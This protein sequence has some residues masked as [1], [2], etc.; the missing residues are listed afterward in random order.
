[1]A[2][3]L[4]LKYIRRDEELFGGC[5]TGSLILGRLQKHLQVEAFQL[6]RLKINPVE[7]VCTPQAERGAIWQTEMVC[8][9]VVQLQAPELVG[10]EVLQLG[11]S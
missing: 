4:L 3:K 8:A 6:W 7:V 1:M 11:A 2:L 5:R 9:V 10:V